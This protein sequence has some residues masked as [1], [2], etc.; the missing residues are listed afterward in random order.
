MDQASLR[1]VAK[2]ARESGAIDKAADRARVLMQE[3]NGLLAG[4]PMNGLTE[5]YQQ[6]ADY[7][8]TRRS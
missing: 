2:A 3:A 1:R 8:V 4:V 7:A 5:T 6:L